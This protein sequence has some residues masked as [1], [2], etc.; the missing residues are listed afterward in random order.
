MAADV[1]IF[2]LVGDVTTSVSPAATVTV[3]TGVKGQDGNTILN[4]T[5]DPTS[6]IGVNGDFYIN[7]ATNFIFGPKASGTW[8]SGISLG[9]GGG[10]APTDSQYVV[11]A[12]A[13]GLSNE[14]V[15][16]AGTGI[17]I[18]DAGAGKAVTIAGFSG[19][20]SS[21]SGTPSTFTPASHTHGNLTN[22]GAIGSTSGLPIITSTSGVLIAGSFGTS[23]GTFCQ[24]NDSRL[25]DS[26]TPTAHTHG[27]ITNDGKIGSDGVLT[28]LEFWD[29]EYESYG[30][31]INY[32]NGEYVFNNHK[33][34]LATIYGLI[35]STYIGDATT[36]GRAV[37]T[38]ADAAAARTAIGA[39]SVGGV[40]GTSGQ[41]QW[42]N[43]GVMSGAAFTTIATSGT[44]LRLTAQAA[45]DT[46][47]TVR[48]HANQ[49]AN[50][51]QWE[52]TD[53]V[54]RSGVNSTGAIGTYSSGAQVDEL[55]SLPGVQIGYGPDSPR[56]VFCNGTANQ[57]W[58]IDNNASIFRWFVPGFLCMSLR[59]NG[60]LSIG[61]SAP[62]DGYLN[63]C[64]DA[65]IP[66]VNLVRDTATA[67][68]PIIQALIRSST[69]SRRSVFD[70]LAGWAVSTDASRRGQKTDRVWDTS[71][72][73]VSRDYSDG[74]R[75]YRAHTV[76]ATAPADADLNASELVFYTDGS[77]QLLIKLKDSGGTV[78]TGT[79]TLT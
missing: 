39:T 3:E 41:V 8:P 62:A 14:R 44:L 65:D 38:A 27:P 69:S 28:I 37:L 36:V 26:R 43:A 79:V 4:G 32:S 59:A 34:N 70:T 71:A 51:T 15:L 30:A 9:S 74:S 55:T 40:G 13:G 12:A 66:L 60:I 47:L 5:I 24:G 10:G 6:G 7:T 19:N 67:T 61:N 68:T 35:G 17:T 23:A 77:G 2:W 42:N 58:Q 11:L 29:S 21:L 63:V 50:L 1:E 33:G 73:T 54:V 16:T 56:M 76:H 57:N 78:R 18:T 48:R 45:G 22:D 46:P 53:G 75:G 25:S 20:Y 31:N 64:I 72:R 52:H 49:T